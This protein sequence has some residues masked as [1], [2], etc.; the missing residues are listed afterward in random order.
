MKLA[1][2]IP[3]CL[4]SVLVGTLLPRL[5]ESG[6]RLTIA[7]AGYLLLMYGVDVVFNRTKDAE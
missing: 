5:I 7:A 6:P 3:I 4:I 1:R 2:L